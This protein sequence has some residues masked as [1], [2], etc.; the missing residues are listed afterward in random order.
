M[1]NDEAQRIATDI[2]YREALYLDEKRW[3]EWLA[4]YDTQIEFWVPAWKSE[5]QPTSDPET[6]V[7]LLYMTARR[8]L[9]ERVARVRSG[10]SAASAVMPRTAHAITNVL[11]EEASDVAIAVR[12]VATTQIYNVKRR[13]AHSVFGRCEYRL[14]RV[15][16]AW[17]IA[18]KKVILL[19]DFIPTMMD[20][21]TI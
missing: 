15:G 20:F 21:Y 11:V 17:R 10:R 14:V 5:D 2:L 16:D 13:E 8:E 6:E 7:S 18:R 4:L 3:D 12:A 9:E 1:T 19:N